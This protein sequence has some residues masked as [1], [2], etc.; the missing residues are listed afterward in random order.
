MGGSPKVKLSTREAALLGLLLVLGGVFL[1]NHYIFQPQTQQKQQL[2]YENTN[3]TSEIQGMQNRI[4]KYQSMQKDE[5]KS[6][7]DYQRMLEAVPQTPMIPN[8]IDYLELSAR[9]GDV[10]LISIHY[11][12]S[13]LGDLAPKPAKSGSELAQVMPVNFQIVASG[14]HYNLLSFILEIE[15][16]PRIYIINSGKMSLARKNQFATGIT[17][18]Q[19]N[20]DPAKAEKNAENAVPESLSY[21][22]DKSILN[23]DFNAYYHSSL[24][25]GA[26]QP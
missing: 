24:L 13:A 23:L 12:D 8:I 11:K 9:E 20:L 5:L 2:V 22:Q 15:N 14:S 4:N 16:A 7:D 18:P 6:W 19:N 1:T 25:N 10:K 17:V 3:L 26:A 21:D